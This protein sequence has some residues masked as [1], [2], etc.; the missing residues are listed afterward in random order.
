MSTDALHRIVDEAGHAAAGALMGRIERQGDEAFLGE[1]LRIETG[2]LLLD[3]AARV[4]DHDGRV[5]LALVEA[6]RDSR[7]CRPW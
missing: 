4:N 7:R 3:A 2:S 5:L 6:L 1:L